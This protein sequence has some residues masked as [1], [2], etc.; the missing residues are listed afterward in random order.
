MYLL[1]FF[2]FYALISFGAIKS[3]L[4]LAT[5]GKRKK[6]FWLTFT[7]SL[8]VI[9]SFVILYIWPFSP[10]SAKVYTLYLVYNAIL[11][12]DIVFK[13][14]L[15]F[16]FI[17]GIFFSKET[18][19][20][21]YSIGLILALGMFSSVLY[22]TLFGRTALRINEIELKFHDLPKSFDGFKIAQISD[23]H[24][25]GF[26]G[27]KRLL[28]RVE[29]E[30][31]IIKPDLILFTGDLVNNYGHE[32]YGW[33]TI[34]KKITRNANSYSILGNHDYGNYSSWENEAEKKKN[35]DEIIE[36]N[37]LFGFK[38]LNNEHVI[39]KSGADSLYLIG[40]ENWGHPPFPQY[41]NLEKAM[42]GIPSDAFKILMTHDPAH[43]DE[44]I[45]K[46]GDVELTLSGHTHGMQW[47][48]LRAG[49]TFSLSYLTRKNWGGLYN[50]NNSYL[51]VNT[52]LGTVGIPWR[53]NMP[54]ELTV[55]TLKRI[56]IDGE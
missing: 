37:K 13:I 40:V 26:M 21:F 31:S 29:E 27:S 47:G 3:I 8:T 45:K 30:I 15:A 25:G 54:G 1:I 33:E 49:I 51:H 41:A 43:W 17:T 50:Y 10:R 20:I 32:I 7:L 6:I 36:D 12:A 5:S 24:L 28:N 55:I 2:A 23:T 52:G 46:R 39:L 22:G 56:E 34:F 42:T 38:L 19:R 53:I 9:S 18:K 11:S 35:L 48:I 16:S 4:R 44:I 14:P